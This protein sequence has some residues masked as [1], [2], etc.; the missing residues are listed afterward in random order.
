MSPIAILTRTLCTGSGC[1]HHPDIIEIE[2]EN[3]NCNQSN[4]LVQNPNGS[5][6]FDEIGLLPNATGQPLDWNPTAVPSAIP[7]KHQHGLSTGAKAGIGV[8]VAIAG[9]LLIAGAVFF[10]LRRRRNQTQNVAEK[11][12][13]DGYGMPYN[14]KSELG[15]G[16]YRG[17]SVHTSGQKSELSPDREILEMENSNEY[18]GAANRGTGFQELEGE[19]PH[20]GG[21]EHPFR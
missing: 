19:T 1:L 18:N 7:T 6:S 8:G 17:A 14:E 12:E 5:G 10:Y 4:V 15:N 2:K 11:S 16:P 21:G 3:C 20:S 13:L 9:L